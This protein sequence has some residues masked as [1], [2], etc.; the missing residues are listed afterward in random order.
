MRKCVAAAPS[1]PTFARP[2]AIASARGNRD[3][4]PQP[5]PRGV[6]RPWPPTCLPAEVQLITIGPW[7]FVGWPGEMSV[8]LGL[9]LKERCPKTFVISLANGELEGYLVTAAARRD[10]ECEAFNAIFASPKGG[11]R[12]IE[13]TVQLANA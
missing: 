7:S 10:G 5:P 8:E 4:G 13:A 6:S 11:N 12:L 3:L 2:S 1:G 9:E